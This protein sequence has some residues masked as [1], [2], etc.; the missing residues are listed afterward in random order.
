MNIREIQSKT[1]LS[2]SKIYDYVIKAGIRTYAMI[3]PLLPG[4]ETLADDLKGKVDYIIVDRMNYNYANWIYSRYGLADK[5]TDEFFTVQA[6]NWQM[7]VKN[8]E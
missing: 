4:A 1:I 3:V 7:P 2:A 8:R 6:G 5:L